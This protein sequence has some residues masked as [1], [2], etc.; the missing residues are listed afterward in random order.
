[1]AWRHQVFCLPAALPTPAQGGEGGAS[2]LPAEAGRLPEKDLA[3]AGGTTNI[4]TQGPLGQTQ[5]LVFGSNATGRGL[6]SRRPPAGEPKPDAGPG[7][8]LLSPVTSRQALAAVP[9]LR[10]GGQACGRLRAPVPPLPLWPPRRPRLQQLG[11][12]C[13]WLALPAGPLTAPLAQ[14]FLPPPALAQSQV[15]RLESTWDAGGLFRHL[16]ALLSSHGPG[17]TVP[18][19]QPVCYLA[20]LWGRHP[21]LR[22]PGVW[23]PQAVQGRG[24]WAQGQAG[25]N[26]PGRLGPRPALPAQ[27]RGRRAF[28]GSPWPGSCPAPQVLAPAHTRRAGERDVPSWQKS[29]DVSAGEALS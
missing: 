26:R 3:S 25:A 19:W 5:A 4:L 24:C 27:R 2:G 9:S 13:P 21:K 28:P 12:S 17:V 15:Q 8:P 16:P 11:A 18:A 6:A 22:G 20:A 1:M 7:L 29:H 10:A 14:K 23:T